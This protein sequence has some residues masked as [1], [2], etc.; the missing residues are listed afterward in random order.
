[1]SQR[2]LPV[3]M[4]ETAAYWQAARAGV[5]QLQRC[6]ACAEVY[7]PPRPFCPSC[8]SRDV[9]AFAA[10]G[11]GTL[12]S[13]TISHLPAPGFTPPYV[14]AVVQL[15]EGPRILSN[16]PGCAPDPA[17]LSLD[18]PL[19]VTFERLTDEVTL[20]QFRPAPRTV[21]EAT[22]PQHGGTGDE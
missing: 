9:T 4:P 10:S 5:L 21:P 13:Y 6:T 14:I 19:E 20:P 8:A 3:P 7:F 18:M 17:A 22:R 1:M 11:K 2:I 16:L 12:Y 15:A